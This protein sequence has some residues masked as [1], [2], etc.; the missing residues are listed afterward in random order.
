MLNPFVE[1]ILENG[2]E[3]PGTVPSAVTG[4]WIVGK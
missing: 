2:Q 4:K 1:A 3:T